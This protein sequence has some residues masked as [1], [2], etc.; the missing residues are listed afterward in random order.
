MFTY[1]LGAYH[2]LLATDS[3]PTAPFLAFLGSLVAKTSPVS[4]EL[5]VLL[6]DMSLYLLE[7]LV[8]SAFANF[9]TTSSSEENTTSYLALVL[10]FVGYSIDARAQQDHPLRQLHA[11]LL[12]R[13]E[14]LSYR[15]YVQ[16]RLDAI[17]DKF[18]TVDDSAVNRSRVEPVFDYTR[19]TRGPQRLPKEGMTCFAI[20]DSFVIVFFKHVCFLRFMCFHLAFATVPF[21]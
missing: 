3:K 13:E 20:L 4:N 7:L 9:S 12:E 18:A 5:C 2:I 11:V 1:S 21:F 15:E 6:V 19:A 8:Q 10:H 16:G 17:L 14:E